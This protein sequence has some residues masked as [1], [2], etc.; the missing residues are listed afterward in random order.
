MLEGIL[1]RFH[2]YFR[3][4]LWEDVP[5]F[6]RGVRVFHYLVRLITHVTIELDE[7]QYLQRA[8]ALAYTTILSLVPVT[9]LFVLYFKMAGKLDSFSV[10]AQTW[11]L[12][13]FVAESAQGVAD[14]ID[15]FVANLHTRTLGTIGAAGL[16]FTAY[17]LLRTVEKSLNSIW[18]VRKHRTVWA[19]FQM[20]CSILVVVPTALIASLYF[21]GRV[22]ELKL[23]HTYGNVTAVMRATFVAVPFLLTAFSL[24]MLFKLMP[25]TL[26]RWRPALISAFFAALL[27]EF[28]KWG[29]NLY[30]VKVIPVSKIYG[31]IG[32]IPVLLLWIYFSW[33]IVLL[34]VELGY[35]IQNLPAL[36]REM[37]EKHARNPLALAVHEDWGLKIAEALARRFAR[38]EG[39]QSAETL[40]GDVELP[41]ESVE[42]HLGVLVRAQLLVPATADEQVS[43]LFS[44]PMEKM[45]VGEIA[46]AFRTQLSLP[47]RKDPHGQKGL[48]EL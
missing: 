27:F 21:S 37:R 19:R 22:Q 47:P 4:I 44:K 9:A 10:T 43:Y 18:K 23:F 11:I 33:I 15:Q 41:I 31:S 24:F 35:T 38:G 1:S 32:L 7:V 13:T 17:S 45:T 36:H 25:N 46:S 2:G 20:L 40:A 39:P 14:Y 3:R 29:F 8:S 34:G 6:H 28:G 16:M 42:D 30:V 5:T 26:V 12:Q 48:L